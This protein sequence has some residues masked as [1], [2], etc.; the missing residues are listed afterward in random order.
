MLGLRTAYGAAILL[1]LAG[2]LGL[3]SHQRAWA[4]AGLADVLETQAIGNEL[5]GG[6]RSNRGNN[7]SP[8]QDAPQASNPA[9][10]A[11]PQDDAGRFLAELKQISL[12]VANLLKLAAMFVILWMWVAAADWVNRDALI[13][14][15]G[16]FKWNAIIFFPFMAIAFLLVFMPLGTVYR[17]PILWVVFVGTWIP[18][19]VVH[20]KHVQP[21]QTVLTGSWW[22]YVFASLASRVG[23]KVSAERK[24]EYEKGAAVELFAI[25]AEDLTTN[26]ANLLSARNSP[27]YLILKDLIADLAERRSERVL[28]DFTQQAVNVRHEIDGVWHNGEARDRESS[29]VMLAVMKT[30]A[31][32]EVKERRKKQ[33]GKFGAKFD[34]HTYLCPLSSQG[35]ATGERV[36]MSLRGEQQRFGS[37]ADLGMREGLHRQWAEFM[38]G[39]QGILVFSALPEG[40]LTTLINVSLEET[41]RLMRDFV[42]IEEVN[43]REMEIQNIA[44]HTYD[45]SAGETPAT[46][47]PKLIRLYPNVYICRDLVDGASAKLLFNEVKDDRLVVTSVPAKE[48]AE[49]LL[50]I[51]QL[52]VPVQEFAAGVKAVLYERLI[53]KLCPDCKVG[54]TPPPD[55][56]QK[57]GIPAGKVEKLYRPPKPEEI[58]KPCRTCQG[59]GYRGRTGVF[60]LL[61]INDQMREILVKQPKV[62]LLKKAARAAQQ[63]LLQ[64]EGILQVAR[65]VTS[66]AELMRVLKQ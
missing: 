22:R 21:H 4:Q 24:A 39:E 13:F 23:V 58:E 35:V 14:H 38:A 10:S 40:G 51:L 17:A 20:N 44:V 55:V 61:V 7:P 11:R 28:L 54:Y 30:L 47:M 65:G 18:Y 43:H 53:R 56:L 12:N 59:L 27:G 64:E 50:R 46:L 29:D 60:E 1:A 8:Q 26:N 25:G 2:A 37:Y 32:L 33:S 5:E 63:R 52:K 48:A 49:A 45:A 16:Y 9:A 42:A 31:N 6:T 3:V 62:D 36:V 19:V 41:D 34:G 57:L 15:L 66:I